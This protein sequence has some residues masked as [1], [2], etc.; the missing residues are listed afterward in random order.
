MNVSRL[1]S[2]ATEEEKSKTADAKNFRH[3]RRILFA[4]IDGDKD[5]RITAD[6][7][8]ATARQ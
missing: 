7:A 4:A 3:V 2:L 6:T 8:V 1:M 5:F